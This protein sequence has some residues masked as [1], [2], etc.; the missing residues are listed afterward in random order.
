MTWKCNE[1]LNTLQPCQH[2]NPSLGDKNRVLSLSTKVTLWG[3]EIST[4]SWFLDI[5]L[6]S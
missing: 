1:R 3:I 4:I 2:L 6:R 5:L